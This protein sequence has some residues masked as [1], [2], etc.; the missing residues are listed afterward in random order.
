MQPRFARPNCLW[1][2][3]TT[4][5]LQRMFVNGYRQVEI[6]GGYVLAYT[7][8]ATLQSLLVLADLTWLFELDFSVGKLLSIYLVFWLLAVISIALGIL[9]SNFCR[10]EGQVLPFVPLVAIPSVFLSGVIVSVDKLP[11]WAQWLS[12]VVPLY[13]ANQVLQKLIEPAGGLSDAWSSLATLPI[14]GVVVLFLATRTL[15]ELD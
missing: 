2:Q 11:G 15:R 6:I 3:A 13:Y 10:T 1:L 9:V 12:H 14:Y 4:L 8:L 7:T 5:P